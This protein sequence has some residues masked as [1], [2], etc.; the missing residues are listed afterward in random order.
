MTRPAA[1]Q[2]ERGIPG[3]S[4]VRFYPSGRTATG[5]T[6]MLGEMGAAPDDN[7]PGTFVLSDRHYPEFAMRYTETSQALQRLAGIVRAYYRIPPGGAGRP[8]I[9]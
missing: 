4:L 9:A 1:P 3:R 8:E 6:F 2:L 7:A 5:W